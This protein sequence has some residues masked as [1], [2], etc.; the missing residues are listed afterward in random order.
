[1]RH[2]KQRRHR[3]DTTD[4]EE[5]W[6]IWDHA[7]S[8]NRLTGAAN[9]R[10]TDH[11]PSTPAIFPT[12]ALRRYGRV[13]CTTPMPG[14][15]G[16]DAAGRPDVLIINAAPSSLSSSLKEFLF[17]GVIYI[18]NSIGRIDQVRTGDEAA[19]HFIG[20]GIVISR[21][22]ETGRRQCCGS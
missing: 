19:F 3:G 13:T 5:T 16:F 9:E 20:Y 10:R 4:P 14:R 11:S 6:G 2:R 18:Y 1:M 21:S 12:T 17:Y 15:E 8:A 7:I 22:T